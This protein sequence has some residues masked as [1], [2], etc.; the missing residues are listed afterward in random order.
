MHREPRYKTVNTFTR[1]PCPTQIISYFIVAVMQLSFWLC[2]QPYI[3]NTL[4]KIIMVT[5]FSLSS[6]L[7]I[8]FSIA[9]SVLDP[10]DPVMI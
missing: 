7:L 8:I 3:S 5:L 9:T 1:K 6:L 10:S 4:T 2:V